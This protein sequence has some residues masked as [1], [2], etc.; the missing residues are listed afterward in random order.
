MSMWASVLGPV[1]VV[2]AV[3]L[4]GQLGFLRGSPPSDLGAR[5][6]VLKAP[7]ATRN[8]VMS[9]A[10]RYPEA[11]QRAYAEI[12]P[13][14]YTGDAAAAITR[15]AGVVGGMDGAALHTA[16]PDYLYATF[17]TRWLRFE[18]DVEFVVSPAEG[19]I[20]LR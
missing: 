6:G 12:P 18:D 9:Q 1:F 3:V 4:V 17:T 14:R 15:L 16:T 8:S 10:S 11:R 2:I 20:H 13:L 19:F 5:D 7:S